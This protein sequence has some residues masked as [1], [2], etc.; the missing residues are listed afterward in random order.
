MFLVTKY[1][2][3]FQNNYCYDPVNNE[4]VKFFNETFITFLKEQ[5]I[6]YDSESLD[7]VWRKDYPTDVVWRVYIK[8]VHDA[9]LILI[10]F[11][12]KFYFDD[13]QFAV[14]KDYKVY[15]LHQP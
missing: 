10:N 12:D 8:D 2:H 1:S 11:G 14:F 3:V 7:T 15:R 13:G 9:H 4:N 6:D 5:G